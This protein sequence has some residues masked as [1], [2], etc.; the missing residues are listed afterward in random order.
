MIKKTL[1]N[2]LNGQITLSYLQRVFAGYI[3]IDFSHAPEYREI[4]ELE[5]DESITIPVKKEHLCF[6]LMKY[7]SG[8]ISDLDLSNWAGLIFTMPFFVPE[9][10]TEEDRWKAGEAPLWIVL[11]KLVAPSIYGGLDS[12]IAR[13]YVDLLA[14]TS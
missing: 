14:C 10:D 8:E 5:L 6:M 1:D 12:T 13:D 11:Q 2:F 4:Q 7:I 9:G 3:L